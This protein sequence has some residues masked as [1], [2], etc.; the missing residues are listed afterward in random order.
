MAWAARQWR[1]AYEPED[2]GGPFGYMYVPSPDIDTS[3]PYV[4]AMDM[5]T[6]FTDYAEEHEAPGA[7]VCECGTHNGGRDLNC[8]YCGLPCE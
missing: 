1:I 7:W 4:D 2:T 3:E 8:V 5:A 6:T